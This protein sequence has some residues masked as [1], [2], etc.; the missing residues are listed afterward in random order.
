[1]KYFITGV[2]G[3][4]KS[5]AIEEL[6]KRGYHAFN[7]D[8]LE[9]VSIMQDKEGNK[10]A[11]LS[12]P[13]DWSRY[14]WNW[15][16][17]A[18]RKLLGGYDTVFV[19]AVVSNQQKFYYLFDKIFVLCADSETLMHRLLSRRDNDYGKDPKERSDIIKNHKSLE[20]KMLS[21]EN[22]IRIDST[23]PLTKVVDD[24]LNHIYDN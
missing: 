9:E 3:V 5:A 22:R 19:G 7:T 8:L 12:H 14:S 11:L 23:Q 10:A 13:I 20:A 1:M 18:L 4:G 17:N 24:I 21:G 6:D 2:P 16:E 15:Q